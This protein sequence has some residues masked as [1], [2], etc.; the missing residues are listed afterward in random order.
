[1]AYLGWG[2]GPRPRGGFSRGRIMDNVDKRYARLDGN[3][4]SCLRDHIQDGADDV[5]KLSET[6][7]DDMA[8]DKS[9]SLSFE[10]RTKKEKETE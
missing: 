5:A 3:R 9:E 8:S 1:M 2:R 6:D 10:A 7:S 4:F